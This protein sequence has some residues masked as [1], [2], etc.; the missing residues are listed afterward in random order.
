MW[1]M[2]L[3]YKE[4]LSLILTFYLQ[5]MKSIMAK[6]EHKNQRS[7]RYTVEN[8]TLPGSFR[9]EYRIMHFFKL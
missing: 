5:S 6:S 1:C 4:D 9:F 3:G 7:F 2:V 8:K